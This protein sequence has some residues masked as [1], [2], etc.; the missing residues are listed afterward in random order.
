MRDEYAVLSFPLS[1]LIIVI[2]TACVISLFFVC[3]TH[4]WDDSQ[5]S[6]VSN[7]L[8][9]LVS[10][11]Q[12]MFEYADDAS[13]TTLEVSFPPSLDYLVLGGLP[14]TA[15]DI[16]INRSLDER[17]SN[18]YYFR[19]R[20]GETSVFHSSVRFSGNTTDTIAVLFPGTYTLRLELK[21]FKGRSYVTVTQH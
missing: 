10:E 2:V 1:L 18:N 12:L 11:A 20:N 16:K 6:Q 4:L 14:S 21:I 5:R 8:H 17:E 15:R 9:R 3:L 19:M 7:E 13:Q